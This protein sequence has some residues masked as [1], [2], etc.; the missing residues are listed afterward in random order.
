VRSTLEATWMLRGVA[1]RSVV[2]IHLP[3]PAQSYVLLARG[4]DGDS[5]LRSTTSFNFSVVLSARARASRSRSAGVQPRESWAGRWTHLCVAAAC[6]PNTPHC[7]PRCPPH[8]PPPGLLCTRE[9]LE[10]SLSTFARLCSFAAAPISSHLT[11]THLHPTPH[12]CVCVCV[13]VCAR[14]GARCPPP[15][16]RGT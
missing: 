8:A 15:A 6:T 11:P 1:A 10:R 3:T 16:P 9:V 14:G 7:S 5:A 13:G 12:V 4:A 2:L